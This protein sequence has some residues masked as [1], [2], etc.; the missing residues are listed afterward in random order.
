MKHVNFEIMFDDLK[1]EV[2]EQLLRELNIENPSDYNLDTVPLAIYETDACE[3][4]NGGD[5]SDDCADCVYNIDYHFVD[6]E[7]VRR[8]DIK[9]DVPCKKNDHGENPCTGCKYHDVDN[10][11]GA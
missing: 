11:P 8:A 5:E 9:E 7:C 2:Q 4:P 6:G 10:C 1:L 3:C